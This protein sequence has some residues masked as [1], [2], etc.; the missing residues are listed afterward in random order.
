MTRRARVRNA[1]LL[2]LF[3]RDEA[4]R[5]GGYEIVF[6]RLLNRRHV[7]GH[8]FASAAVL[9]VMRMLADRPMKSCR[10]ALRVTAQT[11]RISLCNQV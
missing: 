9:R 10:I 11:N 7:T 6:N 1:R 4:E 8:A 2:R 5:M 3:R